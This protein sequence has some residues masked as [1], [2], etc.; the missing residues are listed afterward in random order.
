VECLLSGEVET[1]KAILRDYINATVGFERLSQ[2]V[3]KPAKSVMRMFGKNGNPHAR[4]ILQVISL[5]QQQNGVKLELAAR[6][7]GKAKRSR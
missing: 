4:N 2:L 5:L 6:S 7:V 3:D 1:G